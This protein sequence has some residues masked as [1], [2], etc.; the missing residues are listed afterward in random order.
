MH[1]TKNILF[2]LLSMLLAL[3]VFSACQEGDPT[4]PAGDRAA[5]VAGLV[6]KKNGIDIIEVQNDLVH[7][8]DVFTAGPNGDVYEI[9]FT[10][11]QGY[12]LEL[13]EEEYELA[14]AEVN[15]EYIEIE[16]LEGSGSWSVS[17]QGLKVGETGFKIQLLNGAPKHMVFESPVIPL[18]AVASQQ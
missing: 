2:A 4:G 14:F 6:V 12:E 10:D 18:K 13:P 5:D 8:T 17:I 15:S 16:M 1:Y 11:D 9:V 7:T 3:S